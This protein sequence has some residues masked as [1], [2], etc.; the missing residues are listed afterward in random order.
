MASMQSRMTHANMASSN[1]LPM[2]TLPPVQN[3]PG[4]LPP[5]QNLP[6]N[7]RQN[8]HMAI[9]A[10]QS[11]RNLPPRQ[12]PHMPNL[13][14][15]QNPHMGSMPPQQNPQMNLQQSQQSIYSTRPNNNDLITFGPPSGQP[16]DG[17]YGTSAPSPLP[18][19]QGMPPHAMSSQ[20]NMMPPRSQPYQPPPQG[21]MYVS[22]P[23][24]PNCIPPE[25]RASYKRP[26]PGKQMPPSSSPCAYSSAQNMNNSNAHV[27][28]RTPSLPHPQVLDYRNQSSS[29]RRGSQ[30]SLPDMD[31]KHFMTK[32]ELPS[33]W[34]PARGPM[35]AVVKTENTPSCAASSDDDLICL[36][37]NNKPGRG[38]VKSEVV[39]EGS[40]AAAD[41][42]S[43]LQ[44]Y[45]DTNS[46]APAVTAP[47]TTAPTAPTCAQTSRPT[48]QPPV[49]SQAQGSMGRP[50][51][52]VLTKR[53]QSSP[54]PQPLSSSGSD[55]SSEG[56]PER[57]NSN[58]SGQGKES[59][60]R[61]HQILPKEVCD[62][63][64]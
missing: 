1:P 51:L 3:H 40:P 28:D 45:P 62:V 21:S 29:G 53:D 58:D 30:D 23:V 49:T 43:M 35:E 33:P 7:Q 38:Q 2:P 48:V 36:G 15:Q 19:G 57:P 9:M 44:P 59:Q 18:P 22:R 26:I 17:Q 37:D 6:L 60:S 5:S 27:G 47:S 10:Q 39:S 50:E 32:E 13:P 20:T 24:V 25:E 41:T 64:E 4:N 55:G 54:V 52:T 61:K 63:R 34:P 11:H 56:R 42:P 8:P 31:T 14:P 16:T 46:P 12:N